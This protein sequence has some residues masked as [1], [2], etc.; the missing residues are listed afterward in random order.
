MRIAPNEV[1]AGTRR[2]GEAQALA[3][4]VQR[5]VSAGDL[6]RTDA[7]QAQGLVQLAS[8]SEVEARGRLLWGRAPLCRTHRRGGVGIAARSTHPLRQPSKP[9]RR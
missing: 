2:V 3:A 6:A 9:T 4:D 7:N 5:R 1:D 8:A